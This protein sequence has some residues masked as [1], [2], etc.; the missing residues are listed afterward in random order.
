MKR[1]KIL[2]ICTHNSARSILAE[3]LASTHPSGLFEGYSAGSMPGTQVNPIAQ[4][5][6]LEMG[7]PMQK[8]YSKSWDVFSGEKAPQMDF[9]I[10]VC[11]SAASEPCPVWVGHPMTAHWGFPD[12]SKV[13]GPYEDKK[14]AFLNVMLGIRKHLDALASL[15][16]DQ[17]DQ[18]SL[19][20]EIRK[21]K[22]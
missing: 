20:S 11:D 2:F 14:N 16:L 18:L 4:E 7:Y 22:E 8:M 21:I 5:L 1:Y 15:P 17:L 19:Q 10:T 3:A 9:I 12:P 13:Q 6:A